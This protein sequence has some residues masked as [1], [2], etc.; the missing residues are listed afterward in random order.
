L[1]ERL[2]N[3]PPRLLRRMAASRQVL[4]EL[5]AAGYPRSSVVQHLASGEA[6]T[7]T[8]AYFLLCEAKA[9]TLRRLRASQSRSRDGREAAQQRSSSGAPASSGVRGGY[10]DA[11]SAVA[12]A[13]SK[14]SA[15]TESAPRSSARPSTAGGNAVAAGYVVSGSAR[16]AVAV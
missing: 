1:G 11:A 7:V 14:A 4:G 8:A 15:R 13:V 3:A 5:E 9:D 16:A 2:T 10:A 12:A 6:D